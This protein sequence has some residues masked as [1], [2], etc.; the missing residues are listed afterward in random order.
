MHLFSAKRARREIERGV[1]Q[2]GSVPCRIVVTN[3][4]RCIYIQVFRKSTLDDC[5]RMIHDSEGIPVE[6]IRL[7]SGVPPLQQL[8]DKI[9][10]G[11]A[12][13]QR[14]PLDSMTVLLKVSIT[15]MSGDTQNVLVPVHATVLDVMREIWCHARLWPDQQRLFFGSTLLRRD[16]RL[17]EYG[18]E[19]NPNLNLAA[20]Q[21]G[22]F[23]INNIEDNE[24]FTMFVEPKDTI[25]YVKD[26]L[27]EAEGT[28]TE[29]ISLYHEN[30]AVLSNERTLTSYTLDVTSAIKA[31]FERF[32]REP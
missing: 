3:E 4:W 2:G 29:C 25:K 27:S 13:I 15:V 21:L 18:V 17:T 7:F 32:E 1:S 22:P 30:G 23:K 6:H 28:P 31:S 8:T 12:W 16:A 20:K 10:Q 14:W 5:R 19:K 26:K 24:L 11:L 9:R